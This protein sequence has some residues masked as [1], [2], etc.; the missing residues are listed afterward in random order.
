[1]GIYKSISACVVLLNKE[2]YVLGVSRKT[3]FNDFGLPGGKMEPID[4]NDPKITAIRETKEETGIDVS[5]LELVYATIGGNGN[6]CYTYLAEYDG[7]INHNE[8]H[9]VKWIPYQLL[10]NGSFGKYNDNVLKSLKALGINPYVDI[11]EEAMA[12]EVAAYLLVEFDGAI[13]FTHFY[14]DRRWSGGVHYDVHIG[15]PE[16]SDFE[17]YELEESFDVSDKV[18][19]DLRQIGLKYGVPLSMSID[20]SSK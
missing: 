20:Y 2:G 6:M 13:V 1:M 16:G 9:V 17:D 7:E 3:D 11:D 14:K 15:Y 5:N 4:N 18:D 12:K 8:P 19:E 10:I